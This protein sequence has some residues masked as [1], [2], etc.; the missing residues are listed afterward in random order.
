MFSLNSQQALCETRY[1]APK[2]RSDEG[3]ELPKI[4][5]NNKEQSNSQALKGVAVAYERWALKKCIKC[6]DLTA[7]QNGLLVSGR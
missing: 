3:L 1:Q 5:K 7:R 6:S 2:K 4:N